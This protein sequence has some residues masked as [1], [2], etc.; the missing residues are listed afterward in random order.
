MD[1]AENRQE[2]MEEIKRQYSEERCTDLQQI[3]STMSNPTRFRILC[4]LRVAPFSVTELVSITEGNLSNVSQH[5]KMMWMS[6]Y[7]SKVRKGK[8]VTYTLADERVRT[9]IEM[10]EDMYP[11]ESYVV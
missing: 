11:L 1:A 10:F 6:G 8:H 2:I 5:L 7:V 9:A 4:A 3:L